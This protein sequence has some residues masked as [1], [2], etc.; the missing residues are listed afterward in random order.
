[1]LLLGLHHPALQGLFLFSIKGEK[2]DGSE[3]KFIAF[4]PAGK[5]QFIRGSERSLGNNYTRE[6]ILKRIEEEWE[7]DN[8]TTKSGHSKQS[9]TK[10][11]NT[12]NASATVRPENIKNE[13]PNTKNTDTSKYTQGGLIN[14]KN[15]KYVDSP[16]LKNWAE[17]HNLQDVAKA[18]AE[19]GSLTELSQKIESK[20]AL[21]KNTKASLIALEK[22]MKTAGEILKYSQQYNDCKKYADRL[23]TSKDPDRYFREHD[24]QLTLFNAAETYLCNMGINPEKTDVA[25]MKNAFQK[26]VEQKEHLYETLRSERIELEHLEK[27]E[28]KITEFVKQPMSRSMTDLGYEKY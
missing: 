28:Q 19:A 5:T 18:Y 24:A 27:N 2:T 9:E 23:K 20:K 8:N 7:F 3:G 25:Y 11:K 10:S 21:V 17:L 14:T 12:Q 6:R 13:I 26:M 4:K 22:K 15:Q 1:M 16:R